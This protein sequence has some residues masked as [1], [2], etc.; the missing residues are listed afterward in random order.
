MASHQPIYHSDRN[1]RLNEE[2]IIQQDFSDI[3]K[4]FR[5]LKGYDL[6]AVFPF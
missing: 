2:I 5:L 1:I 4:E 6:Q 3:Y